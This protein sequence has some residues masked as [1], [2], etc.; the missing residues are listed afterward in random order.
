MAKAKFILKEPNSK[1]ETLIYLVYNYQYKRFKYSTREKINPKF[2][3]ANAYRVKASKNF[4][5]YP[6]FNARLDKIENGLNTV[7]RRLLNDGI[8]P[9]NE[10][11]KIA[12]EDELS[13]HILKTNKVSLLNFIEQY[14][15]ESKSIK[16]EGTIKVYSTTYKYLKEYS[17]TKKPIDFESITLEFYNNYLGFLKST[18]NLSANTVGKHIK[19]IKSF[20]NEATDRGINSNLEFRHKKFKTIREEADTVYLSVEELKQIEKLDLKASPRLDK[21]RDLFLIGCYTGLRFSDFTQ[22]NPQNIT[23]NN[24]IIEV[25][26]QKTKQRV[27]IPLHKTVR[28]ILK[29]YKNKLPKAYTNQTMNDYLKDVISLAGIKEMIETT[30]TKGGKIEKKVL[31]KYKLVS[32]HTARRSFATN[33]YLAEVPTISIMKITGHKTERSF[34][35]YIR[36][37][38]KENADKLLTH[39]FFK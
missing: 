27:S 26:T 14:I 1:S 5:E 19:T 13:D 7:F 6:E 38:Q 29:K 24:S 2:W 28:R 20:M 11:L 37:T 12:L 15:E 9:N 17:K 33:L 30:I 34:M 39:P 8:Q 22:I 35:Q 3:N 10:L 4:K 36:V 23:S 16:S 25:R 18:H 32:T 21:V 31:P